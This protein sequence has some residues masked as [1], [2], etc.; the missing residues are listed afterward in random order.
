[1]ETKNKLLRGFIKTRQYEIGMETPTDRLE[2]YLGYNR[3][4]EALSEFLD[5]L[6]NNSIDQSHLDYLMEKAEK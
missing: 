4:L 5:S 3:A 1:M 6:E 2:R